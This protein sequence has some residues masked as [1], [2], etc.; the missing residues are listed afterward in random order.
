MCRNRLWRVSKHLFGFISGDGCGRSDP[1]T[2]ADNP[3]RHLHP[4]PKFTWERDQSKPNG[5]PMAS[6][7]QRN[8]AIW[9]D[10]CWGRSEAPGRRGRVHMIPLVASALALWHQWEENWIMWQK[11]S[12]FSEGSV[13]QK[14]K[15]KNW[16]IFWTIFFLSIERAWNQSLKMSTCLNKHKLLHFTATMIYAVYNGRNLY[17]FIIFR[18]I[19]IIKK[20][21]FSTQ[22]QWSNLLSKILFTLFNSYRQHELPKW[23]CFKG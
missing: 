13:A 9:T 14:K 5:F 8:W 23:P 21:V 10:S 7:W 1:Q 2:A 17:F 4:I 15:K 12:A 22:S 6:V 11:H 3:P 19:W 20:N 18:W 16:T